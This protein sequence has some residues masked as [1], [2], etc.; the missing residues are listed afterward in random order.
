MGITTIQRPL[1]GPVF[2]FWRPRSGAAV[3]ADWEDVTEYMVGWKLQENL[4]DEP[5]T[6]IENKA[7]IEIFDKDDRF[8]QT[9]HEWQSNQYTQIEM[10]LFTSQSSAMISLAGLLFQGI[11]VMAKTP[12]KYEAL[13]ISQPE[14]TAKLTLVSGMDTYNYNV[15]QQLLIAE[16][17]ERKRLQPARFETQRPDTLFQR[18]HVPVDL[19]DVPDRNSSGNIFTYINADEFFKTHTEMTVKELLRQLCLAW[20]GF[21]TFERQ[22][23]Q[24]TFALRT[25]ITSGGELPLLESAEQATQITPESNPYRYQGVRIRF[26]PRPSWDMLQS[27]DFNRSRLD[28]LLKAWKDFLTPDERGEL[29]LL[30]VLAYI[31][32]FP[33]ELNLDAN[34]RIRYYKGAKYVEGDFCTILVGNPSASRMLDID[35]PLLPFLEVNDAYYNQALPEVQPPDYLNETGFP[36]LYYRAVIL[37]RVIQ[38]ATRFLAPDIIYQLRTPPPL[39]YV[40][41][42]FRFAPHKSGIIESVQYGESGRSNAFPTATIR[43]RKDRQVVYGPPIPNITE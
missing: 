41:A 13:Q 10:R 11:L 34:G 15:Y 21:Y 33:G 40:G 12:E 6:M 2:L 26:T 3:T 29:A 7:T 18:I 38:S 5:Y 23:N 17:R 27:V 35:F 36:D 28:P 4:E 25:P 16:R 1:L 14:Y 32:V 30:D 24:F 19:S 42:R 39:P 37:Q 22:F 43:I 31:T 9:L 8:L 20:G